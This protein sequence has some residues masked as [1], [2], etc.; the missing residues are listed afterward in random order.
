HSVAETWCAYS[1]LR[2]LPCTSIPFRPIRN[3]ANAAFP[4]EGDGVAMNN[5]MNRV[6]ELVAD[7]DANSSA[8]LNTVLAMSNVT[9]PGDN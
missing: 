3:E 4:N 9:L 8:K 2:K 7:Y 5:L 1:A 6:A